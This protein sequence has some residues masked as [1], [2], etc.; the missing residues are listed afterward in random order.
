M[1]LIIRHGFLCNR[2]KPLYS[3]PYIVH[4]S[5]DYLSW[6]I[7]SRENFMGLRI[8]IIRIDD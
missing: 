4:F 6:Q 8:V 7:L 1:R 5:T 3:V 2:R